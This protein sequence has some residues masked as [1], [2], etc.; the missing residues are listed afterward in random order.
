MC[1]KDSQTDYNA[2]WQRL[3]VMRET[4]TRNEMFVEGWYCFEDEIKG[5][6]FS[7]LFFFFLD[8]KDILRSCMNILR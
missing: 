6:F 8:V 2:K 4:V 5:S 1:L 7:F 3:K